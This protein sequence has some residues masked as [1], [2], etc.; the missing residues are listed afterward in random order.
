MPG[1]STTSSGAYKGYM[2]QSIHR[3]HFHPPVVSLN[4]GKNMN[5]ESS[6]PQT[7]QNLTFK[8]RA[9]DII[10]LLF[11][12]GWCVA[13]SAGVQFAFTMINELIF[14][15]FQ[16]DRILII[17]GISAGYLLLTG[18]PIL[19]LSIFWKNP[20]FKA[21]YRTLLAGI[22]LGIC[23]LPIRLT[24]YTGSQPAAIL[25]IAG[26]AIFLIGFGLWNQRRESD[27]SPLQQKSSLILR[28]L[29]IGALNCV[30]WLLWGALGSPMDTLLNFL[31]AGVMGFAAAAILCKL[32]WADFARYPGT[33]NRDILL[34]GAAANLILLILATSAAQNN[35]NLLLAVVLPSI[36]WGS[37]AFAARADAEQRSKLTLPIGIIFT[38]VAAFPMML[39]DPDE[40]A[41]TITMGTG[42]LIQWAAMAAG[43]AVLI[44]LWLT[45]VL[46]LTCR[47]KIVPVKK[48]VWAAVA[49]IYV[50]MAILYA[51]SRPGFFGDQIFVILKDQTD[52][53]SAKDNP[54]YNERRNQVYTTLTAEAEKSQ[55]R[56]RAKLDQFH[57][58]YKPYYLV[59]AMEVDAGPLARLWLQSQPEVDRILDSPHLRPLPFKVPAPKG[60]DEQPAG[61]PWNVSMIGA[62]RVWQD[63]NVTGTGIVV[64]NS[65]TGVDANHPD[66]SEQYRGAKS[67]NDYNW[68]DPWNA[69]NSPVDTVGH[70]THTTGTILGTRTGIAPGAQWIGCVNLARNLGNPAYYLD[71]MQFMLAPF[72]EGGDPFTDGKPEKGAMVLNNSWGC[73]DVEGCDAEVFLPAVKALKDAGIF[74]EVSAGNSGY[75]GCGSVRDPL[76]IYSETFTTGAVDANGDLSMFSSLGPVTVDG[77]N[78]TKPDLV[79]PGEN[80]ISTY[81]GGTYSIASGTSMAGPHTVGVVALMW[82]ANPALIGDIDKTEEILR[83]TATPYQG[84]VSKCDA[85]GQTPNNGAG[86]GI[87]NA[88]GA[89][90]AA[91]DAGK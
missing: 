46:W 69:S 76:A 22:I 31:A 88:Y 75:T 43:F 3:D 60:S 68:Y 44:N 61:I 82:S 35:L 16:V 18:L 53:S 2:A 26:S 91:V 40:L 62:D 51:T 74:V 73:P 32:L 85:A 83:D 39:I 49:T 64:G 10:V 5:L 55:K 21:V 48:I 77:S 23:L 17:G 28:A 30:P 54:N 20:R 70:G 24:G 34:G 6:T 67:G 52:V 65:D 12:G 66:L 42:E 9:V 71:C 27:S 59:N 50:L 1:G 72:P 7:S 41:M 89:V 8:S 11:M 78:R 4:Y 15:E 19:L 33:K 36:A 57:I 14:E 37:A 56:L 80:V 58:G 63:F 79:A 87:L 86:Y 25:Q 90:K 81:P 45:I 47:K 29:A 13:L 38:L 84:T